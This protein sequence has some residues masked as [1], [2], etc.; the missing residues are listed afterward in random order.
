ML[1]DVLKAKPKRLNAGFLVVFLARK[2]PR[3]VIHRMSSPSVGV[4]FGTGFLARMSAHFQ[5]SAVLAV[6]A[7]SGGASI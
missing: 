1:D 3:M 6:T 4:V 2:P 7:L 5:T